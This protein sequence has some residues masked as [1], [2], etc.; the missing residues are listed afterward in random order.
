MA[1]DEWALV[2]S[3]HRVFGWKFTVYSVTPLVDE[4]R[5][6]RGVSVVKQETEKG[7]QKDIIQLMKF[8]DDI[9]DQTL[10]KD[11]SREKS[12]LDFL[13]NVSEDVQ[14]RYIR[15]RIDMTNRRITDLAAQTDI[16]VYLRDDM[17]SKA[18]YERH[19]IYFNSSSTRCLFNFIKDEAGLRYFITL[20]SEG[21]EISLRTNRPG[22]VI[23]A[24]KPCVI[25][26]KDTI[27]SVED[28]EAKK[29][30]P[31]F[32]K[33]AISVPAQTE[34][35]YLKTFVFKTMQTYDVKIEGIPMR[36]VMPLK[37]A[38]L[39]L[40]RDFNQKL[41]LNLSFQYNDTPRL[42]PISSKKKTIWL[43]DLGD[44]A[45]ICWYGRDNEWEYE[46]MIRL[47]NEGLKL[48]ERSQF[49]PEGDNPYE[50][51][52]WINQNENLL[53]NFRL[54]VNLERMYYTGSVSLLS[55]ID[56]KIDWFELNITITI[57]SYTLPFTNFY[58]HIL[59]GSKEYILPDETVFILPEEWFEKYLDIIRYSNIDKNAPGIIRLRK[60]HAP[61]LEQ[62]ISGKVAK[63]KQKMVEDL[64][65]IPAIHPE[66]PLQTIATLRPYQKDG[67]YWLHHLYKNNFSGCLAD[68]MGLGKTLQTITLLQFIY[69]AQPDNEDDKLS[70]TLIVVPTSL[71]H[72]WRNELTRFAPELRS[73]VYAGGDRLKNTHLDAIFNT[74]HVILTSYGTM[75]NDVELLHSYSFHMLILDESQYIKNPDSLTYRAV[76]Q[77]RSAHRLALTGTP[78]ENSLEDL[79][80]QFN[81]I[82]EGLLGSLSSFRQLF[83]QPIMKEKNEMQEALLKRMISPFLLRRTKEEVTPE[84][85]P[86]VE[87]VIYCDMTD[88]QIVVYNAEKNR[89]R[90]LIMEAKETPDLPINPI[91]A[92]ESLNKLRQ[93]ANHPE[94]VIP[95]YAEDSGKFDQIILSFE[96]LMQS[97]HKVLIFSSYV[98]YLKLLTRRFDEEGWKYA[99]L[100][101]E[102]QK[103][104]E[105]INRFTNESDIR[106]FFIS[107]KAGST[108]L[109]LTAA[110]YVFIL[111][112]WWN[113]AAEMQAL[114]R[115]HR[116]GQDKTVMAFRFISTD[117]IEEK[118][119]LLQKSKK[120]LFDNF[121]NTNNPLAHF[122]WQ[123]YE[124]LIE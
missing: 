109:N 64:L 85:P 25:L 53:S 45:G 86:L 106:C 10:M 89:I 14:E 22:G 66:L 115:A 84:L 15:P 1:K 47:Q 2:L 114:S 30:T 43:E 31:F 11:F 77:I 81:F 17:N 6:I 19:R 107:L 58:K 38:F 24:E 75:R 68:D 8:A 41:V 12:L 29:L 60:A 61:L 49:Y 94:L 105:E 63:T 21:Q 35:T 16:P 27:H 7:E 73:Y 56:M 50:L 39:S 88:A 72:N 52:E 93:L 51:I 82:N 55:D 32:S 46:L 42:Y 123:D 57:G 40:E 92:L 74:Y 121:V 120:A 95:E 98:K 44:V 122:T 20:T 83:V 119:L 78:L 28:I 65:K 112:P 87:E 124:E 113:P 34:E 79:W 108:G 4:S 18:L 48:N 37:Q 33:D 36:E 70:P 101:G 26:I 100:T 91:V 59:D 69:S 116:I 3:E 110:D 13:K 117:T 103:R 96:S 9:S 76:I 5:E 67:F 104:E 23:L 97:G 90:N 54:E 111:D 102:T 99:L 62:A 71:L 80:A 118:I